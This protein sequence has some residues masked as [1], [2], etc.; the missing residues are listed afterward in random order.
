MRLDK[1]GHATVSWDNDFFT[2]MLDK[3]VRFFSEGKIE[4][5]GLFPQALD[6]GKIRSELVRVAMRSPRELIRL[7]DVIVREH[8]IPRG[9][10]GGHPARRCV[11]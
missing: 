1:I 9:E 2:L 3:R 7:M 4:F 5:A 11:R 10:N 6:V 8:D